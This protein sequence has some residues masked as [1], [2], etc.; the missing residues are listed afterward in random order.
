MVII[1]GPS[2]W[3]GH[4]SMGNREIDLENIKIL[5]I[6]DLPEHEPSHYAYSSVSHDSFPR[7]LCA[8][9][10][11]CCPHL[12]TIELILYSA[13]RTSCPGRILSRLRVP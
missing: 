10:A 1:F 2:R 5:A 7:P 3:R 8:L 6:E 13:R 4:L 12:R 9:P 11:Q